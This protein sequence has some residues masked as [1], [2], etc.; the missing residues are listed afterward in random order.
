ML[1]CGQRLHDPVKLKDATYSG[2]VVICPVI[3]SCKTCIGNDVLVMH[4]ISE[5]NEVNLPMENGKPVEIELEGV[6][7]ESHRTI[8]GQTGLSRTRECE[9]P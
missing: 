9:D 1:R 6:S 3:Q 4:Q 2:L 7:F 5:V 8:D